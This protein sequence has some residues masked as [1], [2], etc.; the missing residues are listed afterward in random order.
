[1]SLSQE[2]WKSKGRGVG[3]AKGKPESAPGGCHPSYGRPRMAMK[4]R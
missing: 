3:G 1:M 4:W 2:R